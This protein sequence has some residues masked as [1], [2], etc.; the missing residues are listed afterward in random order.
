MPFPQIDVSFENYKAFNKQLDELEADIRGKARYSGLVEMA[1][2]LKAEIKSRLAGHVVSGALYR[3]IGHRKIA[4]SQYG[5]FNMQAGDLGL[6]VGATNKQFYASV[7]KKRSQAYKMHFLEEGTKPHKIRAKKG[8]VLKFKGVSVKA[9]NHPGVR[10]RHI[11][12]GSNAMMQGR[13][14]DHFA[15]GAQRALKRH[16]VKLA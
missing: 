6:L 8:G 3:S 7:V 5:L 15:V 16:G 14:L 4:K 13:Y 11:L 2:P 10:A 9:V 12:S 1:K